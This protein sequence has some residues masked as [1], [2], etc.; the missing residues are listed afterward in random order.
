MY[1]PLLVLIAMIAVDCLTCQIKYTLTRSHDNPEIFKDAHIG[2]SRLD[3][4][5][6]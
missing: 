5:S 6:D 4:K 2:F 3:A 1:E